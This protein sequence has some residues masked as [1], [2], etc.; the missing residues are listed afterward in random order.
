MTS[1]SEAVSGSNSQLAAGLVAGL[2]QLSG[3]Q[4]VTF[5][6][7][8][9][10]VSPLDGMV[11]WIRVVTGSQSA[12]QKV[13]PGLISWTLEPGTAI[14]VAPGNIAASSILGGLVVNPLAADDQGLE[15]AEPLFVNFT[16]PADEFSSDGNF[17]LQPGES[18]EIPANPVNGVWVSS[19]TGGHRFTLNLVE[20][21]SATSGASLSISVFGSLH[22]SSVTHQNEDAVI[23]A[24]TVLFTTPEDVQ[25]F[26]QLGPDEL[27]IG[28]RD[29]IR[30]AFSS[31]G[32]FYEE[33][34]L[35][36]YSGQALYSV[37]RPLIIDD[38]MGWQPDLIVSNS[39]PIWLSMPGYV[40]PYPGFR[41][42]VMLYPSFLVT[43]NLTPPFG[44]VHIE[45]TEGMVPVPFLGR[46]LEQS[47]LTK[48][49]VR[50]TLY[51][52]NNED[53]QTFLSFVVQF[54]RDWSKIGFLKENSIVHDDKRP[55]PEFK[56]LAQKKVVVY[57]V[58]YLQGVARDEARQL[59]NNAI[60]QH[61]PLIAT[62]TGAFPAPH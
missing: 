21:V 6:L 49:R 17:E 53:A 2:K 62:E 33:A 55:Q 14:Q 45:E 19:V 41:C 52:V 18:V 36:H 15:T 31:R 44:A 57:E 7:Y 39:L 51:G 43:D 59:I 28:E 50:V 11:Y 38:P 9:K 3:D 24:N 34:N 22:Y 12:V 58:S 13:V 27:Y 30:F 46:H 47:Q 25:P 8:R 10:F 29:T 56:I 42:P 4:H 5:N 54:S 23:E 40:P 35:R 32:R 37:N 60:V 61:V 16:G 48:D 26:N 1:I 20:T